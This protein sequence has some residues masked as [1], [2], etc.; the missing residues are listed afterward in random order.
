MAVVVVARQRVFIEVL[1][2]LSMRLD[3]AIPFVNS[4]SGDQVFLYIINWPL[5]AVV[6]G[7]AALVCN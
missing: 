4:S 3:E 6:F 5:L 2:L 1:S 7:P